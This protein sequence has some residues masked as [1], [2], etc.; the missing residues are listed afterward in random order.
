MILPCDTRLLTLNEML[1]SATDD[2]VQ[3]MSVWWNAEHRLKEQRLVL[4]LRTRA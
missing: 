2:R 4:G 3:V 1:M